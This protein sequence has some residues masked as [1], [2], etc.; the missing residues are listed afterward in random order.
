VRNLGVIDD[1]TVDLGPGLTALTGETGAGKTL[2]VGA[3]GLLL[4]DRADPSVVRAGAD[5]ATVEGRFVLTT[6]PSSGSSGDDLE[7]TLARSVVRGGRSRAWIDGR[8][9][10]VGTLSEMAGTLIE[11][12]GQH[13]HHTLGRTAAQR[14]V[15]DTFGG[16]DLSEWSDARE[17]VRRLTAESAALG[18]DSRERAREV[19]LLRY[20]VS[21]IEDAGIVD[22]GEEE[23]LEAEEERLADSAAH[24][25]AATV[26]LQAVAGLEGGRDGIGALDSLAEATGSLSG[27]PPLAA[28]EGRIRSAM[29]ELADVATDLRSVVETWED[30]P[31]RLEVVRSRRELFHQLRR[32]Y[33]STLGEVLAFAGDARVRLEV[34]EAEEERALALDAEITA[35]QDRLDRCAATVAAARRRAAPRL[36]SRIESSLHD[37]AMPS[38]RFAVEVEGDGAADQVTFLLGANRGEPLLPLAKAASGG[39]LSRTMLAIR[40]A[41]AEV[42]GVTVFDEVDAG[43]G[44]SAATAVGAALADLGR[45]GQVLVVTHLAQVAAQADQQLAVRK[46]EESDRTRSEVTA[47]DDDGRVVE[48]SRMLSGQPDSESAQRHARELLEGL[49]LGVPP[50]TTAR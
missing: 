42:P 9:A 3:L 49:P 17:Q 48:L 28:L 19:D 22:D 27:R 20:Q 30:D 35:A 29:A 1:V 44:G 18:G 12:H 25:M 43:V 26:A 15:L 6:D 2:L 41:V 50:S 7:L 5:E 8:M 37:L 13:Q 14:Q 34:I 16:I 45:H 21:E 46:S 4:G 32:K 38:A 10:T 33:G 23:R 39:E 24:R 36:A 40:L 11:L 47:L 31:E